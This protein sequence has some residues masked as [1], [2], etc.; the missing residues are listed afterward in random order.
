MKTTTS[1][2]QTSPHIS[3]IHMHTLYYKHKSLAQGIPRLGNDYPDHFVNNNLTISN[4]K[5]K[6]NM[7]NT[8]FNDIGS[9][10][11]KDIMV[12]TNASIY[13][14]L[15]NR[16]NQNLCLTSVSEEEVIRAVNTWKNKTS[17]D[18]KDIA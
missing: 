10:L 3:Y 15:E 11:S 16:N 13:D 6:A 1:S 4:K 18:C 5:Y 7:F 9:E 12:S 2:R 17:T 14:Y 8:C